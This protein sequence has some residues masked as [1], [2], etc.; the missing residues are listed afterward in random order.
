MPWN[1]Q[2][3]G[4]LRTDPMEKWEAELRAE[5]YRKRFNHAEVVAA[6]VNGSDRVWWAVEYADL[7]HVPIVIQ[8]MDAE[9]EARRGA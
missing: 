4:A 7:K 5:E 2:V 3:P 8:V 9:R 1:R 6:Y